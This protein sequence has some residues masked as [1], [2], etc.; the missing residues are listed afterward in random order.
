MR[1]LTV[2]HTQR[3][4][5][6]PEQYNN[7]LFL[8]RHFILGEA[9]FRMNHI[10]VFKNNGI[11][12]DTKYKGNISTL[13]RKCVCVCTH[14]HKCNIFTKSCQWVTE[15]TV[16]FIICFITCI[17]CFHM[18]QSYLFLFASSEFFHK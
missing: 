13:K 7:K 12:L 15:S 2:T 11:K 9:I 1:L 10:L 17:L 14:V 16:Y 18:I 4:L 5:D 8:F 3:S 6:F